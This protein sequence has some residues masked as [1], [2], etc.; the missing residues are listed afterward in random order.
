MKKKKKGFALVEILA[1][2]IIITII[3]L[4]TRFIFFD[5]MDRV[6]EK[7][8]QI[9]RH[10]MEEAASNYLT[11]DENET[12]PV[13]VNDL[14]EVKLIEL[15]NNGYIKP[16]LD[17]KTKQ[18]ADE[19]ESKVIVIRET[20]GYKYESY[21]ISPT[22]SKDNTIIVD[23]GEELIA[24]GWMQLILYYPDNATNRKWRLSE[25]GELR[26]DPMLMWQNYTGPILVPLDRI[27]D[28]W[29][30][31]ILDNQE[32]IIPPAG[33]LLVDIS[34]EP[35]GV[36]ATS[37]N[38]KI[39]YDE[40]AEIKQY[41][42]G[43]SGWMDYIRPFIV[44]EKVIVEARASKE[45]NV[46]DQSGNL[47]MTRNIS[48]RDM[49]YI[50]NIGVEEENLEAPT[51][52]RLDPI[53]ENEVA[54]VRVT[55]PEG[56]ATKIF[57]ENYGFE[58]EYTEEISIKKYGTHIVAY[59]YDENGKRSRARG[60]LIND[61]TIEEAIEASDYDPNGNVF[62][63][64]PASMVPAPVIEIDP[65]TITDQV[66]VSV[67]SPIEA[68][69]TY[70]RLGRYGSYQEYKTPIIVKKN[71][72][73]YA[74][75]VTYD[76]YRSDKAFR[77]I[78]NIVEGNKP[79]VKI[80]ADPYP[81]SGRY[82]DNNVEVI[83]SGENYDSLQYSLDGLLYQE[84]TSKLTI[85]E[86]GRIYARG[87]NENGITDRYLDITNIGN[88]KAPNPLEKL[89]VSINVIPE[90]LVSNER[91]S[92]V[93]VT[94]DYDSKATK[95]YYKLGINGELQEYSGKFNVTDNVT[96]YAYA[97]SATGKG[98]TSKKIDNLLTG[99]SEPIIR[100]DPTGDVSK[101]KVTIEF[102]K[103]AVIKR[104][105]INGFQLRDYVSEFVI[106]ENETVIRAYNENEF[107]EI[108]ESTY[109]I[110]N[111]IPE[112]PTYLIDKGKYFIL[113]LTYPPKS[114][115]REYKFKEE[116]EW[117][118]YKE[119]GILLIKP[120]TKS[121]MFE[122]GAL[123]KIEDENGKEIIFTGDYYFIDVPLN[124]LIENIYMRWDKTIPQQPQILINPTES[125]KEVTV[126]INYQN[127]LEKKEYKIVD[128]DGNSS[129][130][131]EYTK[132]FTIDRKNTVIYA[133]GMTT[134]EVWSKES[135]K[136][137]TNIDEEA[138]TIKLNADLETPSRSVGI[139]VSVTDDTEVGMVKWAEGNRSESYFENSGN[140]IA[141]NS[142]FNVNANGIY[143]VYA[144]DMVGNK[145]IKTIT[146]SNIDN[147]PPEIDIVVTPNNII[148]TTI[149]INIDYEDSVIK[150]YKIGAS[151]L[152]WS[153][154][155]GEITLTSYE[156]LQNGFENE[157]KTVTIYAK[158]KDSA[159]NDKMVS[160]KVVNLDLDMPEAPVIN[161]SYGYP[162]LASYGVILDG[163]TTITYEN[164]N[165]IRNEYSLDN[166]VTWTL[167]TGTL[168]VYS[169]TITARSVK[170]DTGLTISVSKSVTMPPD[171]ITYQVYDGDLDTFMQKSN[172]IMEVDSSMI[173]NYI[174]VKFK[175]DYGTYI[176]FL[177]S[178]DNL[179]SEDYTHTGG[180]TR[181]H[182][183]L[184]P[185]GTKKIKYVTN[186]T[187]S[188]LFEI[189]PS[190]EPTFN[191]VSK[192]MLLHADPTKAIKE[193]Y[194]MVSIDF[195]PT[196]VERLYKI[197]EQGEWIN[198]TD[199]AIKVKHGETIYAKGRDKYGYETRTIASY[200]SAV[201]DAITKEAYD[202]DLNTYMQKSNS[203]M[204]VDSSMVGKSIYVKFKDNYGTYIKFLNSN[205]QL[206]SEDYTYTGGA[207]REHILEIPIGTKYINY[208]INRTTS[209]LYEIAPS[210]EPTFSATDG[211]M[212]L[213]ADPTKAIRNPYQM[214]KI[215]YFPTSVQKLYK[216]GV[217]GTW[218][219]YQNQAI[220]VNQN[221]TIYAKGIDKYGNETR[222]IP[223]YTS[224]VTD[225]ML[226]ESYDND[227]NTYSSKQ[228]SIMEVHG[229]MIG[230]AIFVKFKDN[231]GTQIQFLDVN[232]NL[233]SEDYSYSGGAT[234][235]KNLVI[236]S[237]TKYIRYVMGRL[238]N[239]GLLYEIQP[240]P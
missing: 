5:A 152:V 153:S 163:T 147:T 80:N 32:Y 55:Y 187:S 161:S 37:V 50:S 162:V 124:E 181:E 35:V 86:N 170:K 138:P 123:I 64:K 140:T 92:S 14:K 201:N 72:Q 143:T 223:A 189:Q 238:G 95:K 6:Y 29:I 236:P 28:V 115:D 31:Y 25:E 43:N 52:E 9:N 1:V 218:V 91:Y 127:D 185:E 15:I 204:E 200:T 26:S 193:P 101:V 68:E 17:P 213:H 111:I 168:N 97:I 74:Y 108:A 12:L 71:M 133:R 79:Y 94:I 83:I 167:Y 65:I 237:N 22:C 116:G 164:R 215:D 93:E 30:S 132:S 142:I 39:N 137:I 109:T 221:E 226:K 41:R 195:F 171:A 2:I 63:N 207:T 231:Y 240:S 4:I 155:T 139:K 87:I 159:G 106:T 198:Y 145:T 18:P 46:Y 186:R 125:T 19:Y 24:N 169:G 184:I 57:K 220:K 61:T 190:N 230:T 67:N 23:K 11:F 217:D 196:S 216:I 58:Q 104:Y 69:K 214:V 175:D 45:E 150:E 48:G 148:G 118:G 42:V 219:N 75:Y 183:L 110:E 84:Y 178:N 102:D 82:G 141:N 88:L 78:D 172:S 77:V 130:W 81:S 229:S 13:Q 21:L 105:S 122:D 191:A 192:Y 60:I 85:T 199:Q 103:N 225:A 40:E 62:D 135:A 203:F 211:Y 173:G 212:L 90:P 202:G 188:R 54:R 121:E 53:L 136:K 235:E 232:R 20:D 157:D 128:P 209:M 49:I 56:A 149:K 8:C 70:I 233:I 228:N 114:T 239:P 177:D 112:P 66:E 3:M 158:G 210:D 222:T 179:I 224:N 33:R 10:S 119:V 120:E 134:Q 176:K 146:I 7:V 38:V 59:Y 89:E 208:V 126:S 206:I 76:G 16:I 27:E 227:L 234:Y 160:K 98:E 96:I 180:A 129:G 36:M 166:G 107:G 174:Y 100:V 131:K 51:I 44:S 194:Q 34:P 99:I 144:E 205:K 182:I 154:Y 117:K 197:G 113:R 156:V 47:L 73:I 151:N 165:D